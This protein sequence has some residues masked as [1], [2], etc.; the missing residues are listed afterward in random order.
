[1]VGFVKPD[2]LGG[3]IVNLMSTIIRGRGGEMGDYLPLTGLDLEVFDSA[4]NVVLLVVDGLGHDYLQG[5]GGMMAGQVARSLTS[6]A[7]PT[8]ATAVT[9]FLTGV[10]P[11]Q[12]GLTG[13]FVHFREVA[14]V[15]A[16][17]PFQP[18]LGGAAL[19]Q[20]GISA[21]QL[22]GHVPIFDR[23]PV[24]SY[25]VSPA[26]IAES[27]FNRAHLGRA[28]L[29]PFQNLDDLITQINR[30]VLSHDQRKYV[31][32]YW[33]GFDGLAHEHGVGSFQVA[34]H[35][36]R[37]DQGVA[38]LR[39]SMAG[40][41]TLLLVTAD[42]GFVDIAPENRIDINQHPQLRQMLSLPLC[43]EPRMAYCY[44][45]TAQARDFE[46][47]VT[48]QLGHAVALFSS[49]QIL[50]EGWF[51]LGAPHPELLARLGDYVLV[52]K[53]GYA[54]VQRLPHETPLRHIGFHG[55][56]SRAE[57]LVP[58]VMMRV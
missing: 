57:M 4:R 30:V 15:L 31:Y 14:S 34:E 48:E 13:W 10:A 45:R 27:E 52:A 17:L 7:P 11:Q 16:V 5:A 12:H 44:V 25:S 24:Q 37:I 22:L 20:T 42:H 2:Y 36:K 28:Q 49:Q 41:D 43:G 23:M 8:T 35:F 26:W 56:V 21:H 19:G 55:G 1:M 33:A 46:S 6:V 54:L 3:G 51:G 32:A 29:V 47:Y 58:L 9:T 50:E 53:E 39:E 18:R 38:R 40:S